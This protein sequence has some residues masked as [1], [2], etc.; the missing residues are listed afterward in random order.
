MGV[1]ES[2]SNRLA[3]GAIKSR[4]EWGAPHSVGGTAYATLQWDP[5]EGRPLHVLYKSVYGTINFATRRPPP[6][7][8][9]HTGGHPEDVAYILLASEGRSDRTYRVPILRADGGK[10]LFVENA[11]PA[12]RMP[13]LQSLLQHYK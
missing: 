13:D 9:P 11:T 1:C 4:P 6:P 10:K 5:L 7:P 2:I 8:P 3:T 12:V